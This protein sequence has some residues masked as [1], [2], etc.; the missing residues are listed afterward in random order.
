VLL[1]P[2]KLRMIPPAIII[3]GLF[4]LTAAEAKVARAIGQGSTVE[5]YSSSAGVS[6]ATVRAQLRSVFE[7]TGLKRQVELASLLQGLQPNV[8][9]D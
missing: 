4:D 7:K 9:S 1:M 5:E 2:V 6:V 8:S 3:Q